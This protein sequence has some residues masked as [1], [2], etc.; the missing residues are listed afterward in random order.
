MYSLTLRKM[1]I[2]NDSM[3]DDQLILVVLSWEFSGG[4]KRSRPAW[5]L[6]WIQCGRPSPNY[7]GTIMTGQ[8]WCHDPKLACRDGA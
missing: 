2:S 5:S 6:P 8:Q 4:P 3:V 7:L 1:T